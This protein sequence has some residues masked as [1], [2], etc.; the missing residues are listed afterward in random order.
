MTLQLVN[1]LCT[2][3]S[4]LCT[5]SV[6]YTAAVWCDCYALQLA[7]LLPSVAAAAAAAFKLLLLSHA[8]LHYA[9]LS[10]KHTHTHTQHACSAM[11]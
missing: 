9:H 8:L 4:T 10:H 6:L 5:A 2:A 7:P 11:Q 1:W 3:C